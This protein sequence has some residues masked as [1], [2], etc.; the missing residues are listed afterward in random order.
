[1]ASISF[2]IHVLKATKHV[3][4]AP[5]EI[6]FHASFSTGIVPGIFKI[7]KVTPAF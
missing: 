1:M 4:S 7:A 2:L 6:M 5:R 3:T